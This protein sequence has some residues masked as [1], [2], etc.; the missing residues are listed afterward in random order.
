ML[1]KD[2]ME[3]DEKG[4][5]IVHKYLISDT[6]TPIAKCITNMA[7]AF[8]LIGVSVILI[9]FSAKYPDHREVYQQQDQ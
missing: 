6:I 5:Y 4:Y 2:I 3:F 8:W 7:N 1:D 9:I